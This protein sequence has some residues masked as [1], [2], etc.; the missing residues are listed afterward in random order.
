LAG[1][2]TTRAPA[3]VNLTLHV[4]GRRADGY[5]ELE[6]LVAFAGLGDTLSLAPAERLSLSVSGPT[7]AQAE[8]DEDNLVLKA[9]RALAERRPGLCIGAF[10][11]VKRLP[12]AAGLGGGSADAAAALRLLARLNDLGPND[13]AVIGA[14]RATGADVLVCL[15]R[16]A[17]MMSGVG[18]LLGPPL[19]LP[20]LYAV[21]ANPGVPVATAAVF[22]A[23]GRNPGEGTEVSSHP[24]IGDAMTGAE[25]LS[26][27]EEA[28][29][30][31][32]PA[33][34]ML[35][36]VIGEALALMR[37]TDGC[38]LARMSGSGATVFGLFQDRAAAALAGKALRRTRPGWWLKATQ[39]R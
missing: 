35:A 30:D 7:A 19:R 12:V 25:L 5:H 39:L 4:L 23:L 13:P 16:R 14:A 29:N 10:H 33:A 24:V 6:S 38:R 34:I 21:L 1:P 22:Q 20:C 31:L 17:C 3:K 2:L 15:A 11:L 32:E 37:R 9:A 36:P 28:R 8:A 27:L 26:A 18:E